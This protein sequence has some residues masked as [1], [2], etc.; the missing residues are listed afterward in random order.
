M[1]ASNR[2]T[3]VLLTLNEEPNLRRSLEALTWAERVVVVDS[4]STDATREIAC[5]FSNVDF[6][7]RTFVSHQDQWRYAIRETAITSRYVL[8][9]D[10]DMRVSRSLVDEFRQSILSADYDGAVIPFQWWALAKPLKGSLYPPQLRLFRTDQ[11]EIGQRGHTQT[12]HVAGRIYRCKEPLIHDDRKPVDHWI[13]SQMA[14]SALECDRLSR[15]MRASWKDRFRAA[16]VMPLV[17]GTIAYL[18]A[19]GP[20]VGKAAYRY[21]LERFI[22]ESFLAMRMLSGS[23]AKRKA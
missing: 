18:R 8:A 14:Y 7:A 5:S 3:P 21:A 20:W 9:L 10:A 16:G 22:Y 19:G 1:T 17:A 4:D 13:K 23:E 11:V 12:F 15:T 2:V 6:H